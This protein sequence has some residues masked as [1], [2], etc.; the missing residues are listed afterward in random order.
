MPPSFPLASNVA[1][2][3]SSPVRTLEFLPAFVESDENT[4]N[5]FT[6][7]ENENDQPFDIC[8]VRPCALA[9]VVTPSARPNNSNVRRFIRE[10]L[11]REFGLLGA[12][13]SGFSLRL[14]MTDVIRKVA[15]PTS[16]SSATPRSRRPYTCSQEWPPGTASEARDPKANPLSGRP[17]PRIPQN[18]GYDPPLNAIPDGF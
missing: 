17:W 2:A 14:C 12:C 3:G 8:I 13:S 6:F 7:P 18:I 15:E 1:N 4:Q 9:V 10:P 16:S 11:L 5:A